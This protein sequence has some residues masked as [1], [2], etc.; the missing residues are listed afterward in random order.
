MNTCPEPKEKIRTRKEHLYLL[1]DD[2]FQSDKPQAIGLPS[3]SY[4]AEKLYLSDKY[5]G[6]SVKKET[7]RTAQ[8]YIQDKVI[9]V[10]KEKVLDTSKSISEV[11]YEIGFQ[12]PPHFTRLFKQR[13]GQ[14]PNEYRSLN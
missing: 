2:Y 7:G 10:A 1:L 14:A 9:D 12:Y 8:E 13:V 5:F 4:C 3:V 11:G 6:D